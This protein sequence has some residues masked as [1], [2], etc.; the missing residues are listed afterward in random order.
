ML[1]LSSVEQ[2]EFDSLVKIEY[3]SSGFKLRPTVRLRTDFIGG[4]CQFRKVGFL[5]A[6]QAGWGVTADPQDP[7]YQPIS[8]NLTKYMASCYI[9]NIQDLTV[10]F[11][12]KRE[13][14]MLV[15]NAIGRCSDQMIL[16]AMNSGASAQPAIDALK[17]PAGANAA[18]GSSNMTYAKLRHLLEYFDKNA[19]PVGERFLAMSGNN[20]RNLLHSDQIINRFYTSNDVVVD[21][22]LNYKEL[23]GM[24]VITIPEMEEGGLQI[25]TPNAAEIASG[26]NAGDSIRRCYAWHKMALG[27][28]IGQDMRTEISYIPQVTSWLINGLFYAG[29]GLIDGRGFYEVRCNESDTV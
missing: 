14:A 8:V 17:V 11:D 7:T 16:N 23:L 6:K 12:T 20:L 9:D 10:N 26:V 1:S 18:L 28:A 3:R 13:S 29:A 21:G 22:S 2:T 25:T 15:A 19:V 24:Q 5:K 27:M 4:V